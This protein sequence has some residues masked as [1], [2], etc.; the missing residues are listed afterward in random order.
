ML[1]RTRH[2]G[3]GS[4]TTRYRTPDEVTERLPDRL[5]NLGR[6]VVKQG[7]GNGGNGVWSVELADPAEASDA[8]IAGARARGAGR[9]TRGGWCARP[10]DQAYRPRLVDG[11]IR[12]SFSHDKVVGFCHQWPKGLLDVAP[13]TPRRAR[14]AHV[15]EGPEAPA[16]QLLRQQAEQ[17]SVPEMARAPWASTCESSRSSG[18]PTSSTARRT[19]TP[20][21]GDSYVL[22]EINV[23]AVWPFPPMASSTVALNTVARTNESRQRNGPSATV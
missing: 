11:M 17:K 21:T 9:R 16:Y 7:R 20:G 13:A 3:W 18:T 1:Y 2:L 5:G 19:S 22:C 4:D 6:L 10:I 23:S 8:R 12:C 14:T 15:M